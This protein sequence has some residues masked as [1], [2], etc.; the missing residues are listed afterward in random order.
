MGVSPV[1]V[2]HIWMSESVPGYCVE[3]F[4]KISE[5]NLFIY[6]FKRLSMVAN[7][8]WIASE[9]IV[10]IQFYFPIMYTST[11]FA[12]HVDIMMVPHWIYLGMGRK[13]IE[14]TDFIFC[15]RNYAVWLT[16]IT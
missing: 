9:G 4:A 10:I 11:K 12:G 7:L 2:R 1:V 8:E 5:I 14:D 13:V 15:A 6:L 3:K 16:V